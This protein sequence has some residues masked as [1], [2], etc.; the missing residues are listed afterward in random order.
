M[1]TLIEEVVLWQRATEKQPPV[2]QCVGNNGHSVISAPLF[3]F[4]EFQFGFLP[5]IL[6]PASPM[7]AF[8]LHYRV[9]KGREHERWKDE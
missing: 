9:Q 2:D 7:R 8:R 1:N 3:F 6:A 5:V 4:G